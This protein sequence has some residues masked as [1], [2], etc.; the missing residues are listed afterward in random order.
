MSRLTGLLR[1]TPVRLIAVLV[2]VAALALL[3]RPK[4]SHP[5]THTI[6]LSPKSLYA[7]WQRP[8][9]GV[10]Y[11]L[12]SFGGDCIYGAIDDEVYCTDVSTGRRIWSHQLQFGH[13]GVRALIPTDRLLYVV[14]TQ[15]TDALDPATG[16]TIWS[17]LLGYGHVGVVAQILP[18]ALRVYYGDQILDLDLGSGAIVRSRSKG[19]TLWIAGDV[20][21]HQANQRDAPSWAVDAATGTILWQRSSSPFTVTETHPPLRMGT[22][23]LLVLTSD[24][25]LCE[26]HIR[27]G[28]YGWCLAADRVLAFGLASD[29]KVGFALADTANLVSFDTSK[30]QILTSTQFL[31]IITPTET[32]PH[33]FYDYAVVP[34]SVG[35][36]IRFDD[37]LQVF[38]LKLRSQYPG[39]S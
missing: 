20:E 15:T 13:S 23:A 10:G 32:G 18:S 39:P 16:A 12:A 2:S 21:I 33:Y 31:P 28:A 25:R 9:D 35:V 5:P 36:V 24:Q 1:A 38:S 29:Q 7:I 30:G 8:V 19:D 11:Y 34:T 17:T 37:T 22:D 14:A 4:E 26:F 3:L 27:Q 6:Y